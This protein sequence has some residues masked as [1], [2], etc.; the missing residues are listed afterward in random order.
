MNCILGYRIE[1]G[2]DG[3]G[4]FCTFNSVYEIREH[5]I[6]GLNLK[7]LR[8]YVETYMKCP[9]DEY[10]SAN[11]FTKFHFSA[12]PSLDLL[13]EWITNEEMECLISNN[14]RIYKVK[15]NPSCF[16]G[17]HNIFYTQQDLI[18]KEDVTEMV[19]NSIPQEI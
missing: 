3:Y 16:V 17:E 13:N 2:E 8:K 6:D 4:P 10:G 9:W 1:H 15:L 18:E 14:Y 7:S 19:C 11:V 12:A 5:S